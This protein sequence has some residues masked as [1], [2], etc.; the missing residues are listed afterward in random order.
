[1]KTFRTRLFAASALAFGAAALTSVAL[2][3]DPPAQTPPADPSAQPASNDA[4]H[5][6]AVHPA[7]VDLRRIRPVS[8]DAAAG[9]GKAA[10]CTA[11]HGADGVAIAPTFPNLAGQHPDYLYWELVE[12]HSGAV[13]ESPMTPLASTLTDADMRDLAHYFASLP[14]GKAPASSDTP[15]P[16]QAL[17]DKGQALFMEGDS[18]KGIPP[19]QGCHGPDARGNP[20]ANQADRNGYTPWAIYPSLRAQ[21]ALYLQSRLTSFR[22]DKLHSS[23]GDMVMSGVGKQ[24]LDD[25][26]INAVSTW[27]ST[28]SP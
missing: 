14:A 26:T 11:C 17:L 5:T 9:R 1:M 23:T 25:E 7:F 10:V 16:D 2:A 4:A 18:S 3:Q 12:Y 28:Q 13:P 22:D 27:L 8:G 19:C 24:L 15:P 20:L 6:P 21:N